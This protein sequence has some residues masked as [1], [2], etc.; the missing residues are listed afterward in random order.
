MLFHFTQLCSR[1]YLGLPVLIT[2]MLCLLAF[3]VLH[4][5]EH[6]VQSSAYQGSPTRLGCDQILRPVLNQSDLASCQTMCYFLK[7]PGLLF[8]MFS[9]CRWLHRLPRETFTNFSVF[10]ICLTVACYGPPNLS[11]LPSLI[12]STL[13]KMS[14]ESP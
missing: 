10:Y 12:C 7:Q 3:P 11:P 2:I 4:K 8:K 9:L 1:A 5:Q 13:K 14:G 6:M